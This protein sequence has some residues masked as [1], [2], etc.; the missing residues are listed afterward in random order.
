MYP[1]IDKLIM[2]LEAQKNIEYNTLS[3]NYRKRMT[4][5]EH[6]QQL[7]G[8]I[9]IL[10]I[11]ECKAY[12]AKHGK[13]RFKKVLKP[14]QTYKSP[15]GN[16]DYVI[17]S[18]LHRTVQI[19][20]NSN[21]EYTAI[22]ETKSKLAGGIKNPN[23]TIESG[24]SKTCKTS[25]IL[26]IPIE[27]DKRKQKK[28]GDPEF[29]DVTLVINQISQEEI[30]KLLNAS[31]GKSYDKVIPILYNQKK[32]KAALEC[33]LSTKYGVPQDFVES[34]SLRYSPSQKLRIYAPQ[35]QTLTDLLEP[36]RYQTLTIDD[37]NAI[38][39][40]IAVELNKL[41]LD[42]IAHKDIKPDN[43][44]IYKNGNGK[45]YT[46]LCDFGLCSE[47][48]GTKFCGTDCYVS[49]DVFRHS[50]EIN[51]DNA[52]LFYSKMDVWALGLIYIQLFYGINDIYKY[53][54]NSGRNWWVVPSLLNK[55]L[56]DNEL[57][58]NILS[59]STEKRFSS[60]DIIKFL[61][62]QKQCC[63]FEPGKIKKLVP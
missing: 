48:T 4:N 15:I 43:I 46:K 9:K 54:R 6:Y 3:L 36:E 45:Y 59:E 53:C 26:S 30:Q 13:M 52:F 58:Q 7:F 38:F 39:F 17:Q 51:Q 49:P 34:P 56:E 18:N 12:L 23:K 28:I 22:L 33:D 32:H 8:L 44:I 20:R 42:N 63:T 35:G 61:E 41:H 62:Y 29:T 57:L 24:S 25:F 10:E 1:E 19:Y 37:K 2:E 21:N 27:D 16:E 40:S 31:L 60:S 47:I 14:G 50:K 11:P 5:L 55:Y